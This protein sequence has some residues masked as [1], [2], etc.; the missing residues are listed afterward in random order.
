MSTEDPA[1]QSTDLLIQAAGKAIPKTCFSKKL[2]K[3]PWFNESCKKATEERKKAQRKFFSN[4]TLNNV[5]NFKLL[6]AKARHV[7]KQQQQ[8]IRGGICVLS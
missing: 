6:R 1:G 8:R 4:T 2:P 5:Q 3:I 7:V